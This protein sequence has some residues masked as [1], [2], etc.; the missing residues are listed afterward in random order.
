MLVKRTM[1]L[2]APF[3]HAVLDYL[4]AVLFLVAPALLG[5]QSASAIALSQGIGAVYIAASLLTRY[6]LGALKLIPFPVHGVL[7]SLMAAAWIALP[8]V[9]GF[10]DE[11]AARNFF[12]VAGAALLMV[13]W[14][15]DYS[16]AKAAEA[17]S[18]ADRRRGTKDRR[19][20]T[21]QVQNDRRHAV[22]AR[23]R[24]AAAG[25]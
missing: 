16:S 15:T 20:R 7:E 24:I 8:W 5:Y 25:G 21:V 11:P 17:R 6:P 22:H 3:P 23:R 14:L 1:M 19:L 13:A 10:S 4:L 18:A 2:I 12:C 9:A